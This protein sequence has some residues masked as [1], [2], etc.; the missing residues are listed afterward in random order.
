MPVIKPISELLT[1]D[2]EVIDRAAK[3]VCVLTPDDWL[4]AADKRRGL[5]R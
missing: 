1:Y 3:T 2:A 4:K 5:K